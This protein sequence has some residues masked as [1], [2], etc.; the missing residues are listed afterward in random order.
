M[1]GQK[2]KQGF[3]DKETIYFA[4]S[5][6]CPTI[7]RLSPDYH[8]ITTRLLSTEKNEKMSLAYPNIVLLSPDYCPITVRGK[9]K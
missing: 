6:Y 1:V 2:K 7:T 8:P 3:L 5:Y 4:L 9:P